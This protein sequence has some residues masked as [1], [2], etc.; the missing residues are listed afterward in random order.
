MGVERTLVTADELLRL[1]DDGK[2]HELVRGELRT[3]PPAGEEHGIIAHELA[4]L[5]GN[6]VRP[7][8]LGHVFAAETGFRIGRDPDTVLA[9]DVAFV[10]ASRFQARRPSTGFSNLVPDLVAEVVSPFDTAREVEEKVHDWLG[11]GVRLVWVVQPSIRSV[12]VYRALSE[13]R[14]LAENEP[15]DGADV[16]PGFRCAV[17]D[18][19]PYG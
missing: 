12:T 7:L 18:L 9:P 19:F 6:H 3:M 13:V 11:A 17:R 15:L 16:L 10:A 1:P 2:R 4:R 8:G 14:V 5:V